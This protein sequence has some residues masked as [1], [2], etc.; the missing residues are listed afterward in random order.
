MTIGILC[1]GDDELEP[2]LSHIE[3]REE[4]KKALLT[5]HSGK[6]GSADVRALYSGVCRVNA[7]IAAQVLIDSFGA[8]IIINSGTA[9]GI[10]GSLEIFDTV[11]TTESAY[12]DVSPDILTDFHPWLGSEF[13]RSDERL[14]ELSKIAAKK[15][16]PRRIFWGR[17]MTG[18]SFITD[19]G[20]KELID[21]YAPL[22]VDME[23]AGVAQ[24]CHAFGV[25]FIS[26][27][28]ITDTEKQ[29]GAG[30]F[31]KNCKTASGLSAELTLALISELCADK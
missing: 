5:V 8:D 4:S 25:P 17:T 27:R 19:K 12:H 13:F 31:E 3:G 1:A 22:S 9:G 14:V 18:E 24:V 28:T 30:N 21:R 11:V 7:A 16:S 20:R 26:I 15:L 23:T 29:S 10:D 2:F 6:I